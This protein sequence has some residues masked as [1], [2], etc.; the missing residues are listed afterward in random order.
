MIQIVSLQTGE[1]MGIR[2][3][4]SD[5]Y[6]PDTME[7]WVCGNGFRHGQEVEVIVGHDKF[8]WVVCGRCSPKVSMSSDS[9]SRDR[10][11]ISKW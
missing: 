9:A 11:V 2:T 6:L 4:G 3:C 8:I 7:C 1:D 10:G 5:T